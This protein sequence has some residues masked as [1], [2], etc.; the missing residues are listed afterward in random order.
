MIKS[1]PNDPLGHTGVPGQS[2]W[3]S[4]PR[5]L[6]WTYSEIQDDVLSHE[7]LSDDLGWRRE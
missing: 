5:P 2:G 3:E 4:L 7:V 6:A 1:S